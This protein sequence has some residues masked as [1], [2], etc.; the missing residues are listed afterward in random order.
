MFQ[1]V[2]IFLKIFSVATS[3]KRKTKKKH[4]KLSMEEKNLILDLIESG[5]TKTHAASQLGVTGAAITYIMKQKDSIRKAMGRKDLR[6]KCRLSQGQHPLIENVLLEWIRQRQR[7]GIAISGPMIKEKA[8]ELNQELTRRTNSEGDSETGSGEEVD[9]VE[10]SNDEQ[11]SSKPPRFQASEGWLY[12]FK[13]RHG[14]R[15]FSFDGEKSTEDQQAAAEFSEEVKQSVEEN[16]NTESFPKRTFVFG[17]FKEAAGSLESE[18][19]VTRLSYANA[20]AT[21]KL[22]LIS[23]NQDNSWMNSD[24]QN[25]LSKAWRKLFGEEF[26][27]DTADIVTSTLTEM[28]R[29]VQNRNSYSTLDTKEWIKGDAEIPAYHEP[30]DRGIIKRVPKTDNFEVGNYKTS[31]R[32]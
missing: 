26:L 10:G 19:R 16:Q 6:K 9:D 29:K 7:L 30:S 2:H 14:I 27:P 22:P 31:L 1:V 12:K 18:K 8:L 13:V 28:L 15:N 23:K 32:D 21:H 17:G 4:K 3:P 5:K 11:G 25:A 24:I 20:T